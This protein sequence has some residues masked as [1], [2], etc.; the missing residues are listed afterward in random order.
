MGITFKHFN[1]LENPRVRQWLKV[2]SN[3]K[4]YPQVYINKEF[5][6]GIDVIDELVEGGEFAEMIPKECQK[7]P[8]IEIFDQ[9]L[10]SFDVVALIDGTPESTTEDSSKSLI[11]T[12]N[13]NS[14]KYVTVDFSSLDQETRDHIN[15]THGVSTVPYI[16]LKQKPFGGEEELKKIVSDGTL[17]T[18]IPEGSRKL[19][20]ND[21]LKKLISKFNPFL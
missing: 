13:E 11:N 5:I 12:L 8:P 21:K 6:G 15:S 16:F 2:Y 18:V 14:I 4:T 10:K 1:I 19:S 9:M 17:E 20:L 3:W 7:L